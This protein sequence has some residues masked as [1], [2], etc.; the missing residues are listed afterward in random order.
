MSR[1]TQGM[2]QFNTPVMNKKGQRVLVILCAVLLAA[3]LV[4][5][6]VVVRTA[7][8]K[9]NTDKQLSQRM[10]NCVSDAIAEVNRMS[11]V[12]NSGTATRLGIVRQYVYAMD[13]YNQISIAL[14]GRSGALAPQEAFDALY[15]DIQQFETLTQTATSSTLDARTLLLTHLTNLQLVLDAQK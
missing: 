14:H 4:L 8:F 3:A 9:S 12:I 10:M 7:V 11:S 13:Q 6:A 1:Y 2:Q 5:S 15:N